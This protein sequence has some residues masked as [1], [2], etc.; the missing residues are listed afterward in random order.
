M[1]KNTD[2]S[3]TLPHEIKLNSP[4]EWGKETK[5][6]ITVVRKLKAKDFKGIPA[7][8]MMMDDM[9]RMLSK[10]T[11]EPIAFIEELEVDDMFSAVEVLNSFLPSGLMTGESH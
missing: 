4:V 11:N 10:I 1:A 2:G 3:Y 8:N 9:L 7:N 5:D 6:K